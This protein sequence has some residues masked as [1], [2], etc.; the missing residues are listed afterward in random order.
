LHWP[1]MTRFARACKIIYVV[2]Q[3]QVALVRLDVVDDC[4]LW[5]G[6]SSLE[7]ASASLAGEQVAQQGHLAQVLPALGLV[8]LAV[9]LGLWC[10]PLVH[11]PNGMRLTQKRKGPALAGPIIS[12][13]E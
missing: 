10:A 2:E 7:V 5:V 9:G 6:P 3:L 11:A 1:I 13:S 8:E 12:C 4:G